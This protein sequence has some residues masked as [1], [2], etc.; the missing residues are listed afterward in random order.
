MKISKYKV[1]KQHKTLLEYTDEIGYEPIMYNYDEETGLGELI[2]ENQ[3]LTTW[4]IFLKRE[5]TTYIFGEKYYTNL[6]YEQHSLA[7]NILLDV[8]AGNS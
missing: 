8:Q 7:I 1:V 2:S 3:M 4:L 5:K 6:Y